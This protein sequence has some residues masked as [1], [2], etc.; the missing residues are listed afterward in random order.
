MAAWFAMINGYDM[1]L[2]VQRKRKELRL[3]EEPLANQTGFSSSNKLTKRQ[4]RRPQD[5]SAAFFLLRM[6]LS[7]KDI[8][9]GPSCRDAEMGIPVAKRHHLFRSPARRQGIHEGRSTY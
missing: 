5:G 4:R 7:S 1:R 9:R 3:Q 2:D 8:L 6:F